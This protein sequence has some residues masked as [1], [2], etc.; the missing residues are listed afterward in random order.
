MKYEEKFQKYLN[1]ELNGAEKEAIE[2]DM[3][4]LEVLLAFMDKKLDED[5]LERGPYGKKQ[6]EGSSGFKTERSL[7]KAVSKAVNRKLRTYA[8]V[9]GAVILILA[10]T[11]VFGLSPILNMI[12]YN[13]MFDSMLDLN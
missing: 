10:L 3:E 11:L 13:H 4:R 5:I 1:G 6:A 8:V 12:Y 7:I 2:E 9:T